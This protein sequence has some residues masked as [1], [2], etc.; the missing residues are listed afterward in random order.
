MEGVPRF[1]H[2]HRRPTTG[3]PFSYLSLLYYVLETFCIVCRMLQSKTKTDIMILAYIYS[4]WKSTICPIIYFATSD[5]YL[6][7]RFYLAVN[8]QHLCVSLVNNSSLTP[9]PN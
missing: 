9:Q 6:T 5:R 4:L 3:G 8:A 7:C 1:K 2:R